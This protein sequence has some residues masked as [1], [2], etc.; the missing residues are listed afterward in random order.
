MKKIGDINPC[1]KG[2]ASDPRTRRYLSPVRIVRS[3]GNVSGTENLIGDKA[4]QIT[5]GG[6][7]DVCTLS[8]SKG[9]SERAGILL[10]Y[11]T[12]ISGS[13]RIMVFGV[14]GR[15]GRADLH[16][17]FG[18]SVSEALSDLGEKNSCCDHANRD[19]IINVGF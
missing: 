5:L 14:S 16:I 7:E 15:T 9:C 18:E 8:N 10:D 6:G 13:A 19:E 12:E 17:K 2:Y 11:G 1:L 3:Y 4:C